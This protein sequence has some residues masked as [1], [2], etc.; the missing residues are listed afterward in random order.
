M[1]LT[2]KASKSFKI[3]SLPAILPKIT[4]LMRPEVLKSS[5]MFLMG[6]KPSKKVFNLY[7]FNRLPEEL[8]FLLSEVSTLD[9][10]EFSA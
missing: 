8:C 2:K 4:V 7:S 3:F 1:E 9:F 6:L 10:D 5:T